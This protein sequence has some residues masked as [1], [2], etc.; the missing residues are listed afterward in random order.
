MKVFGWLLPAQLLQA[1]EEGMLPRAVYDRLCERL[2]FEDF[3]DNKNK[4]NFP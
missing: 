2:P 4:Y 3:Q 1:T